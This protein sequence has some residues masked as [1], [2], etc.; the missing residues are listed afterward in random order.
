MLVTAFLQPRTPYRSVSIYLAEFTKLANTG[1]PIL[2][3][4]DMELK[5]PDNVRIIRTHLDTSWVPAN[6]QL[7]AHRNPDKDTLE[8]FCIQLQKLWCL[9]EA[10]KYTR[11]EFLIWVDFGAFHMFREKDACSK[12]LIE[13]SQSTYPRD[14][15]L[16]PGCWMAGDYGLDKVC[17]RF[18]GTL[19][20]GHRDLFAPAYTRQM[21]LV[22]MNL[23]KLSWEVNYWSLMDDL[24]HMIPA[25]HNDLLLSRVITFVH[26]H[27]GV[28]TCESVPS[29][30]HVSINGRSA[31]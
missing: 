8:Y 29:D 17:W 27:Q 4:T 19:L 3:F 23:P 24:F 13:L 10:T 30:I 12:W 5:V 22:H 20:I 11:D 31:S 26:K 7:P 21:E 28:N 2:L 6:V 1:V 9:Q 14:R 25:D 15:I 16:A 18:C